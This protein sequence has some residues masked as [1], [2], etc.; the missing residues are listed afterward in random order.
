MTTQ[1]TKCQNNIPNGH[2]IY[3]MAVH[4]TDQLAFKFTNIFH[5]G[6]SKI[7]PNYDF[8]FENTP[9]GNPAHF[10]LFHLRQFASR[11]PRG[12]V[13]GLSDFVTWLEGHS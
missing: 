1:Y 9:S 12:L 6:H 10:C 8:W 3:E 7:Y 13:S 11:V 2:K 4:K 5:L